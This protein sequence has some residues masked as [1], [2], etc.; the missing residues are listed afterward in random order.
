MP[1]ST[2]TFK[3]VDETHKA[4][5]KTALGMTTGSAQH[6]STAEAPASAEAESAVD[7]QARRQAAELMRAEEARDAESRGIREV[8]RAPGKRHAARPVFRR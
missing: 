5:L 6:R 8:E 1:D 3:F 4:N 2:D 7:A